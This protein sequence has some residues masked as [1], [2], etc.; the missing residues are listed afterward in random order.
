MKED[1]RPQHVFTQEHNT[2]LKG[3]LKQLMEFRD[4]LKSHHILGCDNK[5]YRKE[6]QFVLERCQD[7]IR[8][9][10]GLIFMKGTEDDRT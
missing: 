5:E 6:L 10:Q 2:N 4:R 1:Y 9:T 3:H 7:K 8:V